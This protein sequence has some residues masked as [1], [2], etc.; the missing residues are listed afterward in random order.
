MVAVLALAAAVLTAPGRGGEEELIDMNYDNVDIRLV[1]KHISDLTGKNFLVDQ[2]VRGVVTVIS[3]TRI[4]LSEVYAV[5]ES[6]L[7]IRGYATVPSGNLIK[8][9]SKRDSAQRYIPLHSARVVDEIPPEDSII[10]QIIPVQHA[11]VEAVRTTL[12]PLFSREAVVISYPPTNTLI[13]TD[14]ASNVRKMMRIIEE[15]DIPGYETRVTLV[16]LRYA[17]AAVVS[18]DLTP[19]IEDL[20]ALPETPPTPR[21]RAPAPVPTAERKIKIIPDERTNSLLI[22]AS[23]EDTKRI[24]DLIRRLDVETERTRIHVSHLKYAKAEDM[25]RVLNNI[26][27]KRQQDVAPLISE[28]RAT[29]SLII[30]AT[31]E[32]FA[33]LQKIIEQLD[34]VRDQVLVEVLIAE[35]SYEKTFELGVDW[36]TMEGFPDIDQLAPGTGEG[37]GESSFT[38]GLRSFAAPTE[39]RPSSGMSGLS[40]G[41]VQRVMTGMDIPDVAA[42]LHALQTHRDVNIL[43][44]PQILTMDNEEAEINVVRNVPFLSRIEADDDRVGTRLQHIDYKDVGI[45]LRITPRI[46]KERMVRLDIHQEISDLTGREVAGLRAT[47]ETYRR[48]TRTSVLVRDNHT[49]VIGGLVSDDVNESLDKVPFLGDIPLVGNLFRRRSTRNVKT[50]LLV[51]ITPRVVSTTQQVAD[52]TRLKRREMHEIDRRLNE[53]EAERAARER[54]TRDAETERVR[55]LRERYSALAPSPPLP[56]PGVEAAEEA[57]PPAVRVPEERESGLTSFLE[58]LP[59]VSFG[60]EAEERRPERSRA[61]ERFHR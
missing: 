46:S 8:I 31:P 52:L 21:R 24:K 57:P 7:E 5:F 54:L 36:M 25:A 17:S 23:Q 18:R 55:E 11:G 27:T 26:V 35:V 50:N 32:D 41:L 15:I 58:G 3:P 13:V 44:T 48:E 34:I 40:V 4:P 22:V 2:D 10:T 38:G 33:G 45:K 28:D 51:F 12:G 60:R 49:I 30:D 39:G 6:I 9:T 20:G 29:N 61:S 19:I 53:K 56:D 42:M 16:Q 14:I 37:F 59:R 47:P 1:I 43:S